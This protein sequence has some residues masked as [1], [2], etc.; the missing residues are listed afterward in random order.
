MTIHIYL[1]PGESIG[2]GLIRGQ[3]EAK[4]QAD[5]AL[6]PVLLKLDPDWLQCQ[7]L[8]QSPEDAKATADDLNADLGW[9]V[10]IDDLYAYDLIS[11]ADGVAV[12]CCH[13]L[14]E[15]VSLKAKDGKSFVEVD[16]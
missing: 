12:Y 15:T 16:T 4:A 13:W 11:A 7:N 2:Q 8:W 9:N 6:S 1:Q 14:G 5:A 10:G 3:L